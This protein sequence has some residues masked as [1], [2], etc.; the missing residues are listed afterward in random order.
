MITGKIRYS[1]IPKFAFGTTDSSQNNNQQVADGITQTGEAA[2]SNIPVIAPWFNAAMGVQKGARA[3]VKRK[4][5]VN[6]KTGETYEYAANNEGQIVDEVATPMHEHLINDISTGDYAHAFAV[7]T[8]PIGQMAYNAIWGK[9]KQDAQNRSKEQEAANAQAEIDAQA[10]KERVAFENKQRDMYSRAYIAENPIYGQIGA[11]VY[12]YGTRYNGKALPKKALGGELNSL[13]SD[14]DKA[15]GNTHEE[16]GITLHDN[17]GNPKAEIENQEV[18]VDNNKV[19]SDRLPFMGGKSFA[20][21]GEELG[22]EKGKNEEKLKNGDMFARNGAKRAIEGIDKKLDTLLKYQDVVRTNAGLDN[23]TPVNDI[24]K[25]KWGTDADGN[26]VW[27]D[28]SI[29]DKELYGNPTKLQ[30]RGLSYPEPELKGDLSLKEVPQ[31]EQKDYSNPKKRGMSGS[32]YGQIAENMT[33]FLDN[34]VNYGLIKQTPKIPN[35]IKRTAIDEMAMPLN[36][37]YNINPTL[38]ANNQDLKEFKK[39]ILNN[40]SNSNNARAEIASA[41]AKKLKMNNEVYAQKENIENQLKNQNALNLQSVNNR[42]VNNHQEID[43]FNKG[44]D[45]KYNWDNMLRDDDIRRQ[46]SILAAET[47]NDLT[48]SVQDRRMADLDNKKIFYDSLKYDDAA[49]F[50]SLIGTPQMDSLMKNPETRKAVYDSLK[51]G[52]QIAAHKKAK[53]LYGE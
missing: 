24:P 7:S 31:Y 37:N 41:Y 48:N 32:Q 14:V 33:P 40:T 15:E 17:N 20:E 49:G 44:L 50:A 26:P 2:A 13:A 10:E 46:K 12:A 42:N 1:R 51:R 3:N 39:D 21:I 27:E 4:K 5:V 34:I 6:P 38:I 43:N 30:L 53:E 8:G 35:P 22:K 29:T 45:N 52:G 9:K 18:V 23:A 28:D 47:T 11:S 19:L 25:A 36:T 16:G